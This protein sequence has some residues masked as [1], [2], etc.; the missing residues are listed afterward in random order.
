MGKFLKEKRLLKASI[1]DGSVLAL[2][3][4]LGQIISLVF[5]PVLLIYFSPIAFGQNA[6]LILV[7][8]LFASILTLSSEVLI[9]SCQSV[10]SA[11]KIVRWNF[12]KIVKALCVAMV[13]LPFLFFTSLPFDNI[14]LILFFVGPF[15][16]VYSNLYILNNKL[17]NFRTMALMTIC[18]SLFSSIV[19]GS[20]CALIENFFPSFMLNNRVW[21]LFLSYATGLLVAAVLNLKLVFRISKL[22]IKKNRE[23]KSSL[24]FFI[25][26]TLDQFYASLLAFVITFGY[27]EA[28]YGIYSLALRF[29]NAP[30]SFGAATISQVYARN[31][32]N[33]CPRTVF[34]LYF[35][36]SILLSLVGYFAISILFFYGSKF[37]PA[38]WAE[39][40]PFVLILS[41][42][43]MFR[44]VASAL[45]STPIVFNELKKN[46]YI[47]A[48]GSLCP[49]ILAAV[50]GAFHL[51]LTLLLQAFSG[52]YV[53]YFSF[54]FLWYK[55]ISY[56]EIA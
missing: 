28:A 34:R 16:A 50:M 3:S 15:Q 4:A 25:H 40:T 35:A 18:M 33:G 36:V 7:G 32:R 24:Y 56:A 48:I 13:L 14:W 30:I 1:K 19:P 29:L 54:C 52:F 5:M 45:S 41:I 39:V 8:T 12:N 37:I 44:F 53:V 51:D 6:I 43:F 46:F 9:Y 47:A 31:L 27:G 11:V 55:R 38:H 22:R 49:V 2:G 42:G 10:S 26:S 20:I 21:I 17:G 23:K